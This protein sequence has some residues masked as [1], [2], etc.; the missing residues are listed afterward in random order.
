MYS[1]M[2]FFHQFYGPVNLQLNLSDSDGFNTINDLYNQ[3]VLD[4]PKKR[5]R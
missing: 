3:I 4:F 5:V 2:R 1:P